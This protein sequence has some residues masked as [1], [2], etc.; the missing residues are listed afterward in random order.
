MKAVWILL[1]C[2]LTVAAYSVGADD[3]SVSIGIFFALIMWVLLCLISAIF[4]KLVN[5]RG[6]R[7]V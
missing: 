7:P 5:P 2:A 4:R 6:Q 1:C 3:G